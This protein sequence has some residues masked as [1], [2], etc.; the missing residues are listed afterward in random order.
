MTQPFVGEAW[1]QLAGSAGV[2]ETGGYDNFWKEPIVKDSD[3]AGLPLNERRSIGLKKRGRHLYNTLVP[4]LVLDIEKGIDSLSGN[5]DFRGRER[6]T[7]VVASDII[8]GF[9]MY[10][11]DYA[12][13]MMQQVGK[14]DPKS[15]EVGRKIVSEIRTL[16]VK[17]NYAAK[18]DQE[19][20]VKKLD[21][22][23]A[24]K[25][26]QLQGLGQELKSKGEEYKQIR[27]DTSGIP[28]GFELKGK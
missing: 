10:P 16:T 26:R 15:S 18:E 5:P 17:R 2:G 4:T 20:R 22:Q 28:E 14:L 3:V 11:V 24:T 7:S 13:Q 23:I 25:I 12:D 27:E 1:Q 8:G 9:K 6:P 19:R 21:K